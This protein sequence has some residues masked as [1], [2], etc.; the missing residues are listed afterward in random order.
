MKGSLMNMT[1]ANRLYVGHCHNC[2]EAL[3]STIAPDADD[4]LF[5]NHQCLMEAL[6]KAVE[7]AEDAENGE[8]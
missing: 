1:D 6:K 5:C 4:V 3:F 8:F 2:G 7:E